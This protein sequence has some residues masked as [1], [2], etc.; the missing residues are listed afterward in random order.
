MDPAGVEEDALGRRRLACVDVCD[1]ADVPVLVERYC[2]C[3]IYSLISNLSGLPPI[4]GERFVRLGHF[5]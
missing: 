2:R 5:V 3:R 4:M 1:D